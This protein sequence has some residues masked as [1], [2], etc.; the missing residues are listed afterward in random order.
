MTIRGG[1]RLSPDE[2]TRYARQIVMPE[3]G[4]AGQ[5]RLCAARVLIVG[6]GGLGCPASMY[7]TAAGIG[8]LGLV[9]HDRVDLS[10]LGRQV[11]YDSR[12][13][14][15][16]KVEAARERLEAINP[17]V[18]ITAI[19]ER[20]EEG[21]AASLI[22]DWD[23]VLDCTDRLES[24]YVVSDT[25][26]ALGKVCVHGA[27]HRME[28]QVAVLCVPGGPCYRC[29]HPSPPEGELTDCGAA[30]VLGAAAG[31]VG[32]MQACEAIKWIVGLGTHSLGRLTQIDM[33][34]LGTRSLRLARDPDCS[35]CREQSNA[36]VESHPVDGAQAAQ[37]VDLEITA[38]Q[39]RALIASGERLL[40]VDIRHPANRATGTIEHALP[41][42]MDDLTARLGGLDRRW[43]IVVV[44]EVGLRSRWAARMLREIGFAH[45][46][47][48]AMGYAAWQATQSDTLEAVEAVP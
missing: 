44:C 2:R 22:Q 42:P 26:A 7:L 20:L 45:A 40:I 6:L 19:A 16:L 37:D 27:V 21:N 36:I 10:N 48:L 28:G 29:L 14:G 11:A 8:H 17:Q 5:Q 1:Q 25:C 18:R 47:H 33:M 32:T 39:L 24:R 34:T 12:D 41:I 31:V 13:A 15:R 43:T 35:T 4:E 30:G 46:I 9:D 38:A 23:V 3:V